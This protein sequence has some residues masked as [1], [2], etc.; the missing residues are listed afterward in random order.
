M[1]SIMKKIIYMISASLLVLLASCQKEMV[2]EPG[3]GFSPEKV[4]Q[5]DLAAQEVTVTIEAG[6]N[7]TLSGEYDW[8]TP[9]KTSGKSGDKVIFNLALNTT[10]KIRAAVYEVKTSKVTEKLVIKQIGTKIDMDMELSVV[11]YD[12]DFA[13]VQLKMN[14]DGLDIF[15]TWGLR[16]VPTAAEMDPTT[17][18]TDVTIEG[19]PE[20]KTVDVNINGLT[21]DTNYTIWCWLENADGVRLYSDVTAVVTAQE[22]TIPYEVTSLYQR[23]FK[24]NVTVPMSCEELGVCWSL[25]ENPSVEGSHLGQT[26]IISSTI[27]VESINS[28]ELLKPETTY[29]VRPYMIKKNGETVYGEEKEFTTMK[30]P[31]VHYFVKEGNQGTYP[32][33]YFNALSEWGPYHWGSK[34]KMNAN[35]GTAQADITDRLKSACDYVLKTPFQYIYMLFNQLEDGTPAM[36]LSIYA[37][38]AADKAQNK[39][40]LV[41]KWDID[42]NGYHNFEYLGPASATDAVNDFL[43]FAAE[44]IQ[45]VINY[46]NTHTF[47]FEY[48]SANIT[49]FG[50]QYSGFKMREIDNPINGSYDF[51]IMNTRNPNAITVNESLLKNANGFYVIK[52]AK[53]WSEFCELV[54]NE[55]NSANAVLANDIDLGDLQATVGSD[56]VYYKGTFDGQGH[57]LTVNYTSKTAPFVRTDGA[58]IKNLR[59]AGVIKTT[60]RGTAGFI[61]RSSGRTTIENCIS[62]ILIWQTSGSGWQDNAGFVSNGAGELT[63]IDCLFDGSFRVDSNGNEYGGF[64]GWRYGTVSI[65]NCLFVPTSLEGSSLHNSSGT[66][67]PNTVIL[68]NCWYTQTLGSGQG[69]LASAEDYSNGT[70]ADALNAGRADGPWTVKDGKTVLNY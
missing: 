44:E 43:R 32:L 3:I 39:G 50:S 31:F 22:L 68:T 15:S 25:E 13:T 10:A 9:S 37:G 18:G 28:G 66:F 45:Y 17:E 46:F 7:W 6:E 33:K 56:D 20:R 42:E 60:V 19:A 63:I 47:Y 27:D 58:T 54:N 11:D 67:C 2:E 30:D 14:A 65:E 8:I 52:N 24:I 38:K 23:E 53:H 34:G 41:F 69:S 21:T 16:Y 61:A 64:V 57:T 4:V 12:A 40:T 26:G 49:N 51:N 59:T 5:V 70:L 1:I 48:C 29:K 35:P 36:S 62:S 55:D